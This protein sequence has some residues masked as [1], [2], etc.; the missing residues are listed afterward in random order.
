MSD[1]SPRQAMS[2]KSGA[3]LKEKRSAKRDKN[4][5]ASQAISAVEKVVSKKKK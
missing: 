2:K 1:K 5:A 3:S 4:D